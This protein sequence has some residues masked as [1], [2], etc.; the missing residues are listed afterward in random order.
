MVESAIAVQNFDGG[1]VHSVF[2]AEEEVKIPEAHVSVDGHYGEAQ[3]SQGQ[4]QVG[5]GGGFADAAFAGGDD[6]HARG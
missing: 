3:S 2:E 1:V 6:D 5:G 4:A